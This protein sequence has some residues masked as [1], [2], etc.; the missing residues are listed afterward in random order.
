MLAVWPAHTTAALSCD[1][2]T[3]H[4]LLRS[5]C[6]ANC[7]VL[8]IVAQCCPLLLVLAGDRADWLAGVAL[9]S[10][11]KRRARRSVAAAAALRAREAWMSSS[12]LFALKIEKLSCKRN[13]NN[14]SRR[15][16]NPRLWACLPAKH[17]A[18]TAEI[19]R[20]TRTLPS[21]FHALIGLEVGRLEDAR[22]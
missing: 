1:A 6:A 21:D 2:A 12:S 22:G 16:S 10:F 5:C 8:S 14:R 15:G 11:P 4:R 17:L 19:I 7:G 18:Q 13:Q 9:H 3:R 20:Q